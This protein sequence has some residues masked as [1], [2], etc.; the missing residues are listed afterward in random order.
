MKMGE[1]LDTGDVLAVSETP[2]DHKNAQQLHDEL[3][4]MG[5]T[6]IAD[7]IDDIKSGALRARPQDDLLATYA[8]MINKKDGKIDFQQDPAEIER[9]IRAMNPWPGAYAYL[10]NKQIKIWKA[11]VSPRKSSCQPG[12]ITDVSDDGISVSAGGKTLIIEILQMP[13]KKRMD[14]KDYLR[15]NK[16][17]IQSILR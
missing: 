6:L 1:G 17:E 3:A 5:A 11:S 10:D 13:G 12:T 4:M 16:I 2:V 7:T 8:P 9:R 15:G 14:V